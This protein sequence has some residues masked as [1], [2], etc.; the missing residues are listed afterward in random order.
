MGFSRQVG[1]DVAC[2]VVLVVNPTV[3]GRGVRRRR[4]S[5]RRRGWASTWVPS[6]RLGV[7][8]GA[9]DAAGHRRGRALSFPPSTWSLTWP[10]L[11]VLVDLAAGGRRGWS[12]WLTSP[13]LPS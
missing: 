6:T 10:A 3:D 4:H 7:D 12:T 1:V 11:S 13:H 2:I 9:I 8:V 5:L